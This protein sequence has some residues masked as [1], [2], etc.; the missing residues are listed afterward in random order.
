MCVY[1]YTYMHTYSGP[2]EFEKV[3]SANMSAY[4]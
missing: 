2:R 4:M 1:M 3:F